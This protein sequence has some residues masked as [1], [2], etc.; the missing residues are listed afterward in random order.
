MTGFGAPSGTG[1]TT[2]IRDFHTALLRQG[3]LIFLILVVLLVAW[4]VLRSLQYRRA[5]SRGEAY[6]PPTV[7]R[8]PE[9][10]ARRFLR[11]GFGVLWLIDGL[12]QLQPGMPL[13]MASDVIRPAASTSP[14]W[15][16][17]LVGFAADTWSRH[18]TEAAASVVWI[19]L[20]IGVF[21]LAAPR[22]WWSRSAGLV[23]AGWGVLI[24]MFGE[25]FG[26]IFAPG[27]SVLT[28]APGGVVFYVV[29]GGLLALPERVWATK[30][31][32]RIVTGSLGIFLLVMAG[33]QAWPGRG[34]WQGGLASVVSH[35]ATTAQPH[36]LSSLVSD[37]ASF[38]RSH[39][40]AVNLVVVVALAA[41]GLAFVWGGRWVRPALVGLVVVGLADWILVED[42]GI[43]GGVG[44][45]PNSM[46]PL[47][48]VATTGY[49]AVARVP[50][51]APAP[52]PA[53]GRAAVPTVEPTGDGAVGDPAARR[54][55]WDRLEPGYAG[56]LALALGAVAI[57][58]IGTAPMVAAAAN[59]DT[60]VVLTE[61]V[62]GPPSDVNSPAPDFHLIDQH[63]RPVS[64]TDLRGETV[65]LTFLDPVCTT[66]CPTIAQEFRITDQ[67]L[68]PAAHKVRFVAVVANPTYTS[69]AAVDA[70][71]R[72]E[73]LDNESN[74]LFL[75]GSRAQLA[76]VWN[77]YGIAAYDAPAGGMS[78]HSDETYLIDDH[79]QTRRLINS[80]PGD[81]SAESSSFS[82]LLA[83]EITQ[84]MGS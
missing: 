49:L 41:I 83:R 47:L 23:G 82:S 13:G 63:G 35:N 40:W 54:P 51:E 66:D 56:R 57:V 12:L 18:P 17:S 28:G 44:T 21:L 67:M 77:A 74:W 50:A 80:D 24:W 65:A 5:V 79:G 15:V 45:D 46:V 16:Q 19:Q 76:T 9:P 30:E 61:S 42:L 26:G 6:P 72:Q 71:D 4:N 53:I 37:F 43:F 20:G 75:T 7:S 69:V 1:N 52:A 48:L 81:G 68:G 39:G 14:G 3:A 64:L 27:L 78:I 11:I 31:L 25:A 62:N 70:F 2:V 73:H 33:L 8:G 55:W 38:D 29:A 59:P 22:G 58:L 60:D 36:A 10:V 34:W 32:G 84:V